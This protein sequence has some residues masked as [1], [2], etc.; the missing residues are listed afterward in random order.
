[1][2]GFGTPDIATDFQWLQKTPRR[3]LADGAAVLYTFW[4]S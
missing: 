1:M 4:E 2:Q 3:Q